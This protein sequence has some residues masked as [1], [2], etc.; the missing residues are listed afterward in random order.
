MAKL[1]RITSYAPRRGTDGGGRGVCF[2]RE[3]ELFYRQSDSV[4]PSVRSLMGRVPTSVGRSDIGTAT[5]Q[6]TKRLICIYIHYITSRL[7]I[8]IIRSIKYA[9]R[10]LFPIL[11]SFPALLT[12]QFLSLLPPPPRQHDDTTAFAVATVLCRLFYTLLHFETHSH[13][14]DPRRQYS[15]THKLINGLE[16]LLVVSSTL[17][18]STRKR[19]IRPA[20]T[21][22][23]NTTATSVYTVRPEVRGVGR[24]R[25]TGDC[26]VGSL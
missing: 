9:R 21:S 24:N 5:V 1:T 18:L 8:N 11:T 15:S 14:Q 6:S 25:R 10:P 26:G 17:P 20:S 12:I 2:L 4:G 23:T 16:R 19:M 7:A 22:N 13:T 3:R